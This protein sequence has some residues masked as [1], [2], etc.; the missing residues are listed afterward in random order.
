MLLLGMLLIVACWIAAFYQLCRS[1]SAAKDAGK[2]RL[3][4]ISIAG[5]VFV[6]VILALPLG[7]TQFRPLFIGNMA[8]AA[9][10]MCSV[11][12][13]ASPFAL[14][15][16]QRPQVCFF[17]GCAVASLLM[18]CTVSAWLWEV[19]PPLRDIQF[20]WRLSS[21][22]TL[23]VAF[24]LAAAVEYLE[25]S[26]L[27]AMK[28]L[29]KW[30]VGVVLM[31]NLIAWDIPNKIRHPSR[32]Q[33]VEEQLD[34]ML[35]VYVRSSDPNWLAHHAVTGFVTA[36]P[37]VDVVRLKKSIGEVSME[38]R[39]ASPSSVKISQLYFPN[40]HG[41]IDDKQLSLR[42]SEPEGWISFDLPAGSHEIALKFQQGT[43][44]V[45]G[46]ITTL[47]SLGGLMSW[48]LRA[49]LRLRPRR[50]SG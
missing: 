32:W 24:I 21:F 31:V 4:W 39:T 10:S 18:M 36:A 15:S 12:F 48:A 33:P 49:S 28:L 2:P 50:V 43:P 5:I 16:T 25:A 22:L 45:F 44:E 17:I 11:A 40:W 3:V 34:P 6:V 19:L 47:V 29:L 41:L 1:E 27:T 13:I 37:N 23:S 42:G 20:P 26:Q 38:L 8:I 35:P 9:A 14:R 46:L 7:R 30:T